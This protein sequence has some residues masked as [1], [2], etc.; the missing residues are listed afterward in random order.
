MKKYY[1]TLALL[2]LLVASTGAFVIAQNQSEALAKINE[3]S[4]AL[5]AY[6]AGKDSI[7][8]CSKKFNHDARLYLQY[9]WDYFNTGDYTNATFYAQ[10]SITGTETAKI[11]A[12]TQC[13]CLFSYNERGCGDMENGDDLGPC[14]GLVAVTTGKSGCNSWY[15]DRPGCTQCYEGYCC[16]PNGCYQD[17]GCYATDCDPGGDNYQPG[18]DGGT[19]QRGGK[20]VVNPNKG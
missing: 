5:N 9:S 1:F 17:P 16:G 4:A 2:I 20:I 6:E 13:L 10:A 18:G 15:C 7:W 8:P 14:G 11:Y 12:D 19:P 3:A